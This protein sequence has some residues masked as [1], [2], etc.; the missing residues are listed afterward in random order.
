MRKE[1]YGPAWNALRPSL[2]SCQQCLQRLAASPHELLQRDQEP[3]CIR[4]NTYM[5]IGRTDE[6]RRDSRWHQSP[7]V[8]M[9]WQARPLCYVCCSSAVSSCAAWRQ[10]T[11]GSLQLNSQ[12]RTR[13]TGAR[14]PGPAGP[15]PITTCKETAL[16]WSLLHIF[17]R[18]RSSALTQSSKP[19]PPASHTTTHME[20]FTEAGRGSRKGLERS[21]R[22]GAGEGGGGAPGQSCVVGGATF[23]GGVKNLYS[24]PQDSSVGQHCCCRPGQSRRKFRPL[25]ST[26]WRAVCSESS[27]H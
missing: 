6:A 21:A 4:H 7:R 23:R 16:R 10:A 9:P 5:V 24:D 18:V 20:S 15:A 26:L 13:Y 8:P 27:I 1:L 22:R 2:T 25:S 19:S 3:A 17:A 11:P 12:I 14:P